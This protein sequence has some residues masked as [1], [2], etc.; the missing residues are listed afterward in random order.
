M[1][2][3]WIRDFF[4]SPPEV[5][6]SQTGWDAPFSGL[7][8]F[9]PGRSQRAR[10]RRGKIWLTA[11]STPAYQKSER[12]IFKNSHKELN[13]PSAQYQPVSV[14]CL[15]GR[16]GSG[17][18]HWLPLF[19]ECFCVSH[20][21]N[22]TLWGIPDSAPPNP[23]SKVILLINIITLLRKHLFCQV[24]NYSSHF[25]Y[26]NIIYKGKN[27]TYA[28][29]WTRKWTW[30]MQN[31][32]AALPFTLMIFSFSDNYSPLVQNHFPTSFVLYL[33]WY[34]DAFEDIGRHLPAAFLAGGIQLLAHFEKMPSSFQDKFACHVQ[35]TISQT[36]V[37]T[38]DSP[39]TQKE[40]E[41]HF[42]W[43]SWKSISIS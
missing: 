41:L 40:Q 25:I 15:A 30:K 35:R 37:F 10:H 20:H 9:L 22:T 28:Q 11:Q 34:Q 33:Q 5:C 2:S 38:Y 3:I 32:Q 8:G 14:F 4:P 26:F 36:L 16:A 6:V 17:I 43:S 29:H 39:G 31:N 42:W 23:I 12:E 7:V 19:W 18:P 27:L 1:N 21:S 24:S 13:S